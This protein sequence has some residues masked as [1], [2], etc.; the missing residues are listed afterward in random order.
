MSYIESPSSATRPD[1]KQ[2]CTN[3]R[4]AAMCPPNQCLFPCSCGGFTRTEFDILE[5]KR[6]VDSKNMP[7]V[8]LPSSKSKRDN[9]GY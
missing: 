9:P 7:W 4:P 1:S 6:L 2:K 3:W 8:P 5:Y